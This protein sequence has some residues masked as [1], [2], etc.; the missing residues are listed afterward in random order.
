MMKQVLIINITRIGDLAQTVPLLRRLEE[1]S[2]GVA[3]DLVIDTRLAPMA[4]LLPGL[5]H[6]HTYDLKNAFKH[7]PDEPQENAPLS[8]DIA[9]WAHSLAT[10]G[11]D[12]VINLTFTRWSGLLAAAIGAVDTRGAVTTKGI[13]VLKNPWLA[14]CVDMHQFRRF[15]RFNVADL[16]ALGGSGH[17]SH[18]PIRFTVPSQAVEWARERVAT[19]CTLGLPLVAVQV[20]ASK[21]KKTWRPE[22]FGQ[23]MAALSRQIPCIFVLTGTAN[24]AADVAVAVSAYRAAGGTDELCDMV[25]Q[26]NVHQLA[27]LLME[28]LLV[29]AS[30]TGPMHLAVGVG[31]PIINISVGHVDFRETGPYGP[32]H[33]VVQ[34]VLD[35]APCD[36]AEACAYH[37]CKELVIPMQ[38]AELAQ[39]VLGL[40]PFSDCWTG[41]RVYQSAID[42]DGLVCYQQRAGHRDAMTEWYGAFWR[43][44]WYEQF[45]GHTSR[46]TIDSIPPNLAEQQERFWQM[47]PVIDHVV[48]HAELLASLCHQ[49]MIS[50]TELKAAQD[51]LIAVRQVIMP[52]AMGSPAFGPITTALLRDLYDGRVLDTRKRAD[53]Q[54][55]AYR[56]WKIRIYHVMEQLQQTQDTRRMRHSTVWSPLLMVEVGK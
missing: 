48:Q 55:Q 13:S 17:G 20:S 22:Y 26:T 56:T 29:L 31:T 19:Y 18:Q 24:D 6:I 33:W 44:F 54:A 30:D 12:R 43:R 50:A 35:C 8:P 7:A 49:P 21:A 46:V 28:C 4:A 36:M 32:G 25:G 9:A 53:H 1:E 10:V 47:A 15:N 51:E 38:V 2:P 52:L 3:I 40:A 41:A 34:P 45:T 39:H 5:R 23:T 11:Y 14:Y 42:A 27:A 16:F 37:R